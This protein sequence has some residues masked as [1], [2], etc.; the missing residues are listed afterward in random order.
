MNWF[1]RQAKAVKVLDLKTQVP[2]STR[3]NF[4]EEWGTD[5]PDG[6][7]L[8]Q[9][10]FG[11]WGVLR[12]ATYEGEPEDQRVL[13]MPPES[14]DDAI[15]SSMMRIPMAIRDDSVE[16]SE[17]LIANAIAAAIKHAARR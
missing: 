12:P 9:N 4:I 3:Q 2:P 17:R 11:Q 14:K 13:V 16:P 7:E 5:I 1:H 8:F 6:Y 15:D 10:E